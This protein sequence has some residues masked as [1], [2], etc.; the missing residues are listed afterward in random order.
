MNEHCP[1]GCRLVWDD[2]D[3]GPHCPHCDLPPLE[4]ADALLDYLPLPEV[5]G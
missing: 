2:G 4:Q 1:C 3:F 5:R